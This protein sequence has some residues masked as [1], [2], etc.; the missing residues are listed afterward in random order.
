LEV[1]SPP[2]RVDP[3]LYAYCGPDTHHEAQE[4]MTKWL[5]DSWDPEVSKHVA[6]FQNPQKEN[7]LLWILDET[8]IPKMP[9]LATSL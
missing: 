9:W 5:L 3:I 7:Q 8:L 2:K 4:E 1:S 6:N